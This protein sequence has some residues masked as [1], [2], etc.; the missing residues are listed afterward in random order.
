MSMKPLE[1]T[2]FKACVH[3]TLRAESLRDR[4]LSIRN[5]VNIFSRLGFPHKQLWGYLDK[6][7]MLGFYEYGV[8]L[9]L[10]WFDFDK[11]TPRYS[12]L[13]QEVVSATGVTKWE[14]G[15]FADYVNKNAIKR[16][17]NTEFG[18]GELTAVPIS[19][20]NAETVL[21]TYRKLAI[22]TTGVP[23]SLLGVRE[24][25]YVWVDIV[26]VG[27][28]I[29][30]AIH[31]ISGIK[32]DDMHYQIDDFIEAV[33]KEYNVDTDQVKTYMMDN[34][35]FDPDSVSIDTTQCGCY[36]DGVPEWLVEKCSKG[37]GE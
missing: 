30:T 23:A 5:I 1:N 11:L 36:I 9:D 2:F 19:D 7:D 35:D 28:I 16:A 18:I 22:A 15:E 27:D 29:A 20:G 33:A 4:E 13:Y 3:E 25:S 24:H 17:I 37:G 26:K 31:P 8:T 21:D 6:W 10:G 32:D 34:I 14:D 12:E